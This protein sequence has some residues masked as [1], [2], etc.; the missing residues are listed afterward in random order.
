MKGKR[1]H[2]FIVVLLILCEYITLCEAFTP[3]NLQLPTKRNLYSNAKCR[4]TKQNIAFETVTSD[5]HISLQ[6]LEF[7][8][9]N[10]TGGFPEERDSHYELELDSTGCLRLGDGAGVLVKGLGPTWSSSRP[11]NDDKSAL[12]LHT[13][14]PEERSEHQTSLGDLISCSRLLA[15]SR[16]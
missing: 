12:F 1:L 7:L 5:E 14:H 15:C 6:L 2:S 16:K 9:K 4:S 8:E 3:R 11:L 13:S 10:S